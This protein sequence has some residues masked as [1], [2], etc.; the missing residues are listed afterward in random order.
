MGSFMATTRSNRR[1]HSHELNADDQRRTVLQAAEACIAR[2][3]IRKTTMD[4]IAREAGMSRPSIYRFF[5]DREELLLALTK[6]HSQALSTKARAFIERQ[7]TFDDALVEG[8]VYLADHGRRD[9]FTRF[10]VDLDDSAFGRAFIASDL[11]ATLTGD[12][13]N[14]LLDKAEASKD[15]PPIDRKM[16]QT[17]LAN[18]GLMLMSM[19]ESGQYSPDDCRQILRTFVVPAFRVS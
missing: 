16:V 1:R 17:W 13:W 15:I 9:P 6:Q 2:H 4:D 12:F 14:S 11:P 10:L 5:A 8:L 18:I 19:L 3:G 7:P